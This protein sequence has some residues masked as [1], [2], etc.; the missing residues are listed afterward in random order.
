MQLH[1]A[2]VASGR[3]RR[4]QSSGGATGGHHSVLTDEIAS[5]EHIVCSDLCYRLTL[6]SIGVPVAV[7]A[8]LIRTAEPRAPLAAGRDD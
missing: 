4:K 6:Q 8:S 2:S 7:V 3:Q 5:G 1:L